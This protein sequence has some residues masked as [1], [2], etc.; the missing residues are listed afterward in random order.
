MPVMCVSSSQR[1]LMLVPLE[2]A[3]L[4]MLS[5]KDRHGLTS[6]K[7]VGKLTALSGNLCC[8]FLRDDCMGHF[9]NQTTLF[10]KEPKE[11]LQVKSDS[12]GCRL[13]PSLSGGKTASVACSLRSQHFMLSARLP[14]HAQNSCSFGLGMVQLRWPCV[15]N[16]C[17]SASPMPTRGFYV[18]ITSI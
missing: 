15:T 13:P 2:H 4:Q 9:S 10:Q 17:M 12:A 14:S 8:L 1:E 11:L 6:I 3:S 5:V 16:G 7:A 18:K